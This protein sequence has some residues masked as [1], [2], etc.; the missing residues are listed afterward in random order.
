MEALITALTEGNTELIAVVPEIDGLEGAGATTAAAAA[1]ADPR[2]RRRFSAG[3]AWLTLGADPPQ[4]LSDHLVERITEMYDF[5]EPADLLDLLGDS[6]TATVPPGERLLVLDGL[7]P[8]HLPL[9]AAVTGRTSVLITARTA[10]GLPDGTSVIRLPATGWPLL[11]K[12]TDAL[13]VRPSSEPDLRDPAARAAAA[14]EVLAAGLAAT[15]LP[16]SVAR[17]LELGVFADAGNIPAGLA[18]LLWRRTADLTPLDSELT[19][20][21]LSALGLLSQAPDRDVLLVPDAVRRHLRSVLGAD[22]RAQV[23]RA[24][25]EAVQDDDGESSADDMTYLFAH[26]PDHVARAGMDVEGLVC[27]GGWI[28]AKLQRFLDVAAV[29]R[30]LALAGTPLAERLR[31]TLAQNAALLARPE[32]DAAPA[33][34]LVATLACRLHATPDTAREVTAGLRGAGVPWLE[35][36]WPSP[37]LPHPA[38]RRV[39]GGGRVRHGVAISPDGG[40]LA[41]ADAGGT[42]TLWN[43]DGTVR[44][45]L[46]GHGA[47]VNSVAISPDGTWLA[48]ASDDGTV[49][50]WDADGTERHVLEGHAGWVRHVVIAP[51]GGW[52][53][54]CA[55]DLRAWAP[56]GT[57]LWHVDVTVGDGPVIGADGSWLAHLAEEPARVL[58]WT[59]EGGLRA[60][61]AGGADHA[62]YVAAHPA[63]DLLLTEHF[64]DHLRW[65]SPD[66]VPLGAV[67]TAETVFGAFTVSPDGTRIAGEGVGNDFLIRELDPVRES[68][69]GGHTDVVTDLAFCPAGDWLA[70]TSYDGT[71]RLWDTAVVP[72]PPDEHLRR[73]A[74]DAIAVAG[75]GSVLVTAGGRAGLTFWDEGG[76]VLET[77]HED[78]WFQEVAISADASLIAATDDADQLWLVERDGKVRH[79]VRLGG[80]GTAVAVA[81]D[82]S[83]VA[84]GTDDTVALWDP[85]GGGLIAEVPASK[86]EHLVIGPDGGWLAAAYG[87]RVELLDDQGFRLRR[88]LRAGDTVSG[89]AVAPSGDWLA[90]ATG[91]GRILRWSRSGELAEEL[92]CAVPARDVAVGPFGT[93]LA[94]TCA[95]QAVRVWDVPSG[96][97]IAAVHLDAELH[98]CA[99]TPG[100]ARLYVTSGA[101]LHGFTLNLGR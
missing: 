86:A 26:L 91:D 24:L 8:A 25:V 101:G 42:A 48:T 98:R 6:G 16:E 34:T 56:D 70:S 10:A 37:D 93:W 12:L 80:R 59:R 20:A 55:D 27:D 38:S 49:R 36:R 9:L 79:T 4:W 40:W 96:H 85:R 57:P 50:L 81:P 54:S 43:L 51:D 22:A 62:H 65:W 32:N 41:T 83:W 18:R 100:G 58:V 52:L 63:R 84:T 97:C 15:R 46:I 75:D 61:L 78:D 17:L 89:L 53:A 30:D 76:S 39:I 66:G 31:R 88:P 67:E 21:G 68:V 94:A 71:V 13:G 99:W 1:C 87:D 11:D 44:G 33:N 92:G 60:E 14:H 45:T 5:L 3:T 90:A 82:G 47:D 19:L 64:D 23:N 73:G 35:S 28:T 72:P 69:L 2:V 74:V 77:V 95:D 29:E 7:R